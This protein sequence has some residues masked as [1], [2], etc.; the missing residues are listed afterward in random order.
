MYAVVD[1]ET[2]GGYALGNRITEVAIY[3]FNG[4]QIT[5]EFHSLVNPERVI[6]PFITQL[7]G[8]SNDMVASAPIFKDI[9]VQIDQ[10]T[11]DQILVAHNAG[12]DYSFLRREFKTVGINYVRKKLCTVRLSRK[13]IPGMHSYSLGTLCASLGIHIKDRHRAYGDAR[14]TVELLEYLLANDHMKQISYALNRHSRE[15]TLPPNLP[16]EQFEQLPEDVGIYYFLDKKG[17][18]IYVGKSKNIRN[19]VL[20]H[21]QQFNRSRRSMD[22][23]NQIHGIT[24]EPCGNE[25]IAYLLESHEIKRYWPKFNRS[26]RFTRYCWGIF[27]YFD[28][29]GYIRLVVAQSKRSDNPVVSFRSFDEAWDYL[30]SQIEKHELCKRLCNIQT[31]SNSCLDYPDGSCLGA[32]AEKE[33]T[34]SYNQRVSECLCQF[35]YLDNSFLLLGKGRKDGETSMVLVENGKYKGFGFVEDVIQEYQLTDLVGNIKPFADNQDVQRIISSYLKAHPR[36]RQIH[37]QPETF[38]DVHII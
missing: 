5:D 4:S 6:P 20:G 29:N 36:C 27:K 19:R 30:R 33:S 15:G 13:I 7:T 1:L 14:A 23:R 32:C 3:R 16:R 31:V 17:K 18:V 25:L 28:Q 21:F 24:F 12:F 26:Q 35:S 37:L 38:R 22:F 34:E 2:T 10:F 11:K 8:I 9:A